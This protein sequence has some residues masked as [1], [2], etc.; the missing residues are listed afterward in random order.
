MRLDLGGV[1]H[2]PPSQPLEPFVCGSP[3]LDVR[4][5]LEDRAMINAERDEDGTFHIDST[6]L[7][8]WLW[9]WGLVKGLNIAVFSR[10]A[11]RFQP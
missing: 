11:R 2:V 8:E 4:V 10:I 7:R 5:H 6:H 9:T 1:P 3:L